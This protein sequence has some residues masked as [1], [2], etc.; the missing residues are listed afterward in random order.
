[1]SWARR[2]DLIVFDMDGVLT[3]STGCHARA[4]ADLWG[5]IP[6]ADPPAYFT[7]A[8]RLTEEV[9]RQYTAALS[10]SESDIHTWTRFKQER[11]RFYLRTSSAF[12]DA[13]PTLKTLADL[14]VR[15]ALGTGASRSTAQM[16]LR[17]AGLD[18]FLPVVVTADD[19]HRGKPDP[20]TYARAMSMVGVVPERSLVVEDSA[21]GLIAGAAAG[22]WTASVRTG[23]QIQDTNFIGAFGDLNE[24]LPAL[25]PPSQRP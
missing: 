12:P 24:L 8:G 18:T 23:E 11:A 22:A 21:A 20:E 1:V 10:P 14:D 9:V 15:L 3:D 13:L 25:T 4:F 17:Q 7:I 16:L 19:V 5:R 2:F 6:I